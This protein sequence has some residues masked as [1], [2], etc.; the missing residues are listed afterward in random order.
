MDAA[1]IRAGLG[2]KAFVYSPY[3]LLRTLE[4]WEP[5]EEL[6][7]PSGIRGLMAATYAEKDVPPGWEALYAEDYGQDLA[8]RRLADMGTDI[9]QVALDDAAALKTRLSAEDALMVL[10]RAREGDRIALLEGGEA[11]MPPDG[12]ISL[13]AARRLHRNTVRI[14]ASCLSGK[15]QDGQLAP[16]HID[17]CLLAGEGAMVAPLLR[18]G[19]ALYWDEDLG[20]VI[21]KEER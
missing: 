7:L 9:W 10:A 3:V 6:A 4:L 5:L 15:P 13:A 2:E 1:A 11:V 19:R 21:R 20:V 12:R 8:D 16:Y 14:P 17:G 18:P